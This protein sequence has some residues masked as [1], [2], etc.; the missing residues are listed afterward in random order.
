MLD[1]RFAMWLAWERDLRFLCND[2]DHTVGML[3]VVVEV[4]QPRVPVRQRPVQAVR[5]RPRRGRTQPEPAPPPAPAARPSHG[6]RV[7]I[8]LT[9]YGQARDIERSR[10]AGFSRHLVKPVMPE[11]LIRAVEGAAELRG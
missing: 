1:S 8:A 6:Q 3:C 5:R 9:G 11:T 10:E 2:A 4:T 7:L